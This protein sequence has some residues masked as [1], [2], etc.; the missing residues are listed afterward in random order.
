MFVR[1]VGLVAVVFLLSILNLIAGMF[2]TVGVM[3]AKQTNESKPQWIQ[4]Q[5]RL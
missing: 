2:G 1:N 5:T 3:M 4:N